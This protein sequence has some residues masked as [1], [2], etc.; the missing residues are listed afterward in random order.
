MN[1]IDDGFPIMT[2]YVYFWS[3]SDELHVFSVN[4][5]VLHDT[6]E[7]LIKRALDKYNIIPNFFKEK[8]RERASFKPLE[9]LALV[10]TACWFFSSSLTYFWRNSNSSSTFYF[11]KL[12]TIDTQYSGLWD[13]LEMM[14]FTIYCIK[15]KCIDR[16][17]WKVG[18]CLFLS[19]P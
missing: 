3:V 1:I 4:T 17:S 14:L 16:N 19:S 9:V 12:T 13:T 15:W 5:M 2:T 11:S 7:S 6:S 10:M 8:E 18:Y